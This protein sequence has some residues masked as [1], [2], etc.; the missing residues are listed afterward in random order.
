MP[1]KFTKTE[2]EWISNKKV[3]D[4]DL[5]ATSEKA[6]KDWLNKFVEELDQINTF[7]KAKMSERIES[8]ITLQ[9]Q[10]YSKFQVRNEEDM[11]HN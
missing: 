6:A 4:V 8:F 1:R 7:Y 2:V 11:E 10:Y 3:S 9:A 5:L